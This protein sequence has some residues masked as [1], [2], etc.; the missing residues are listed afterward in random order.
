MLKIDHIG[1][2]VKRMERAVA[3]MKKLGYKFGENI[4]DLDRKVNILFGEKDGY[5]VELVSPKEKGS[6]VDPVLSNVGP[7][8]YHICYVS[9]DF[10]KDVQKMTEKG[11][12]R[13]AVEPAPAVAFGGRRVVFLYSLA[14]GLLELVEV[15]RSEIHEVRIDR[16][17]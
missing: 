16:L 9:N 4:E 12:Y 2:A 11:E 13:I 1:Y 8:P 17:R 10:D 7:T 5:R 14:L 6:P 15:E 3:T